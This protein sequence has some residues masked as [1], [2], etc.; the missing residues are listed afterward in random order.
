MTFILGL[1]MVIIVNKRE[2]GS[3]KICPPCKDADE[4]KKKL[5]NGCAPHYTFYCGFGAAA[6][7]II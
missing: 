2:S 6:V 3:T 4:K 7:Q 1:F 5:K